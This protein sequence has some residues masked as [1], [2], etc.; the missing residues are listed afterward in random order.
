MNQKRNP[1]LKSNR[2]FEDFL[3]GNRETTD[4]NPENEETGDL[5]IFQ[6][7]FDAVKNEK[8]Y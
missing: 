3:Y 4:H 5:S 7:N 2:A 6:Q 1:N 8:Y